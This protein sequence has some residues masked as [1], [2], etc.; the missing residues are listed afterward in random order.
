MLIILNELPIF[1]ITPAVDNAIKWSKFCPPSFLDDLRQLGA[2]E[3]KTEVE[4]P[5]NRS[6]FSFFSNENGVGTIKYCDYFSLKGDALV[7]DARSLQEF[8]A[9]HVLGS[10]LVN[11]DEFESIFLALQKFLTKYEGKPKVVVGDNDFRESVI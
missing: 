1:D 3:T 2:S 5:K 6:R 8:A 4:I 9:G 10:I 7:I 11:S